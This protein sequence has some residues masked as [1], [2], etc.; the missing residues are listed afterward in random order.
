MELVLE[1]KKEG[2]ATLT[3]T[4]E[5]DGKTA[6][7]SRKLNIVEDGGI[8]GEVTLQGEL[9]HAAGREHATAGSGWR[10]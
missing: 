7:M 4:A 1:G 8:L 2:A 3:V 9:Y 6:K 10:I 5:M